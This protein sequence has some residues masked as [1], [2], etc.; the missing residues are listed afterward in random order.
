MEDFSS[1]CL[2]LTGVPIACS[3]VQLIAWAQFDLKDA[4]LKFI[5]SLRH[6]EKLHFV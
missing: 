2:V 3:I 4:K 6:R 1:Y 5:K